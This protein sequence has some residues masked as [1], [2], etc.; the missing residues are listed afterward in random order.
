MATAIH[1]LVGRGLVPG[2][3]LEAQAPERGHDPAE[4]RRIG[5]YQ[6]IAIRGHHHK[7][8]LT[9]VEVDPEGAGHH[10]RPLELGARLRVGIHAALL[11]PASGREEP[12]EPP[13][14]VQDPRLVGAVPVARLRRKP[15]CGRKVL[16]LALL[17]RGIG[18]HPILVGPHTETT[19]SRLQSRHGTERARVEAAGRDPRTPP[20]DVAERVA[21]LVLLAQAP[22]RRASPDLHETLREDVAEGRLT[23]PDAARHRVAFRRQEEV[24]RREVAARPPQEH[25]AANG[26]LQVLGAPPWAIGP[27]SAP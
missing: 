19:L 16:L 15:A 24:A 4:E 7:A 10:A 20:A 11:D 9:G 3:H 17:Y 12:L 5:R 27:E 8:D 14:E 26:R 25:L 22:V 2:F 23:V 21:A 6:E 1:Y 18:K 13:H